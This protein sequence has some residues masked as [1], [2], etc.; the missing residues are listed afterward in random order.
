MDTETLPETEITSGQG[1][2]TEGK[3]EGSEPPAKRQRFELGSD[4]PDN[5]WSLPDSLVDYLH[6]YMVSHV[7]EKNIQEKVL[8]DNPVTTNIRSTPELDTFIRDV[9]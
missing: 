1:E 7:S 9:L 6:K 5:D 8:T 3:E 4:N 2:V